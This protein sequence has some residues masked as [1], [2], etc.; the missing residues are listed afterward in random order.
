[1]IERIGLETF[2][3]LN[4]EVIKIIYNCSRLLNVIAVESPTV[5]SCE[6]ICNMKE[7]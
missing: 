4:H 6:F 5:K 7:C 1:M 3:H 2:Y